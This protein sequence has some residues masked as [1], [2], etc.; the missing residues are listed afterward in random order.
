MIQKRIF[1][2]KTI[3]VWAEFKAPYATIFYFKVESNFSISVQRIETI[4]YLAFFFIG[5]VNR[6]WRHNCPSDRFR[7][8]FFVT[9]KCRK[10]SS[11][12][13]QHIFKNNF[14]LHFHDVQHT[15]INNTNLN[16][17]LTNNNINNCFSASFILSS[18]KV[19]RRC[20]AW[21]KKE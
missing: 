16:N 7:T 21:A 17:F 10:Y 3:T 9:F 6:I 4:Y 2:A 5:S 14:I 11:T 19:E 12:W 8:F 15:F 13:R 1:S 18:L 20:Y